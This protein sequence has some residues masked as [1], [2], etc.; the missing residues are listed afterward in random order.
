MYI[1]FSYIN[2]TTFYYFILQSGNTPLHDACSQGKMKCIMLLLS[3]GADATIKNNEG[4]TPA[5]KVQ[6]NDKNRP[7][8][9]NLIKE[10]K[11]GIEFIT[12]GM[13]LSEYLIKLVHP[14]SR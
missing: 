3:N 5:D 12:L 13:Y 4:E 10:A 7:T 1:S 9:L 6:P 14:Q 2:V 11:K 8:I